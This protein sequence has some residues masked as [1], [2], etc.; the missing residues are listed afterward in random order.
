MT[1]LEGEIDYQPDTE[2][3]TSIPPQ[4]PPRNSDFAVPSRSHH[5]SPRFVK[6]PRTAHHSESNIPV[7]RDHIIKDEGPRIPIVSLDF[8]AASSDRNHRRRNGRDLH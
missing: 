6:P 2:P 8:F 5:T 1:G 7:D 3:P 4:T